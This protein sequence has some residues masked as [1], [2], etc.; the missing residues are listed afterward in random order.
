[1]NNRIQIHKNSQISVLLL[2]DNKLTYSVTSL[3]ST[4]SIILKDPG[5]KDSGC[6]LSDDCKDGCEL[7]D[8]CIISSSSTFFKQK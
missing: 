2:F 4:I 8:D 7:P 5:K 3:V 6:M 1:M